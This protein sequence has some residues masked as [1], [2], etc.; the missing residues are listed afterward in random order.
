MQI[1][2][3]TLH[4]TTST[5]PVGAHNKLHADILAFIAS[6]PKPADAPDQ[7]V[8]CKLFDAFG[9]ATWW[10]TEYDAG[11]RIGF[12]YVTGLQ[13]DEWGSV[14]I[15]EL[16]ELHAGLSGMPG[17]A[18]RVEVDL[19]FRPTTKDEAV[20]KYHQNQDQT[21][22]LPE[23]EFESEPLAVPSVLSLSE[24]V[25]AF[26]S[27]LLDAVRRQ[28]P[29]VY[30]G[31][32]D[33]RREAV[34]D[35]LTR[36]PFPAQ[37]EV[38]QAV[39]AL[40]FDE[41]EPAGIIN[42][43][44]GTGKTMMAIA[45]AAV[46]HAEG[47]RRSLVIC[48]P[49]L[50]YK[51]RREIK[52]TVPHA[53]VWVLNGPDTLRKL[54][55]LREMRE[56]PL[57]P[58]FFVMGRVRMRMGYHWKPAFNLKRILVSEEDGE[59]TVPQG[60]KVAVC[61]HCH[62]WITDG[63]DSPLTPTQA[64]YHL[65]KE[66]R[67]CPQCRG[68]LWT[69]TRPQAS[70]KSRDE[71]VLSAMQQ[72]PTIGA[73]TAQ[74]LLATFGATML[75]DMLED[76]VYEFINLMDEDG[77][78]FFSDRQATRME[79]AMANSEFS[80]GQGGYQPTE[81]IK[82][83]L[84][85]GYFGLLIVDEGH[86][87]KNEGSAQGQAFG[88]LARKCSKTLLL[89]GTLMGG[90]ADDLFYLLWRLQPKA[91]MEDGFGY[92]RRGS[93][94]PASM[95]FLRAHGVIKDIYKTRDD[96]AKSHRTARGRQTVHRATKGPGFG[97]NGI[98]RYVVPIT[99]FL[100][101]KQIGG[102]VLPPYEEH[103]EGVA[104]TPVQLEWYRKLEEA[105]KEALKQAL[106]AGDHSLLGVVLNAL[107]AWP[108]CA[109]RAE[110]VVHPHHRNRVLAHVPA[111]FEG[112]ESMP[113]ER[114]LIERVKAEKTRGRRV[115]VYTVYTGTRDTTARLKALL[116]AE[117][118]KV[119]T[120]SASVAA[121]KRED[122][123]A[124][125][126]DRGIDVLVTNPELVKTGLDLLEFPTIVFLQSGYNVYTL[127]QAARRSW[128]I[129]QK[130]PVDVVFLGYQGTAQMACLELMAKKI[131]VAQSTSGDMPE[132]GLDVLN[133]SGDSIEVALARQ[134]VG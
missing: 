72:L 65:A 81:F 132:S 116:A 131:A 60:A 17:T 28:N 40:L 4:V 98:M 64:E 12:G 89:T 1:E 101:L 54:L 48:P 25:K 3:H 24:F 42:A 108:D 114:M 47:Y 68:A 125:Q 75:G 121:E 76:N 39:S 16:A 31:L 128:R 9:S 107:L 78:L 100:K 30:S 23:V 87:F 130:Q 79:R 66:R 33:A 8:I 46:A 11:D 82:R 36:A 84:P 41:D 10:L 71:M 115:L 104:M 13:F 73:K 34:M 38:V 32:P 37:R 5:Q 55:Q 122:W 105:L 15:D 91:M 61:P 14:S 27:G 62:T 112:S 18:P 19:H 53:R 99:A 83:Y 106:R 52:Q 59:S 92:S 117:G 7:W 43:E 97:P 120:L 74:R 90:Y 80:F 58:E 102:N 29:P 127:Q 93:L 96:E 111:L 63:D 126:V 21:P 69:L 35:S 134:L 133:Q 103:F 88:V 95:G 51:W 113:K 22:D 26:G 77:D 57:H 6:N 70:A 109:F 56:A 110:H 123:V 85:Q 2:H 67:F 49:H 94:G 50:V 45:A 119:A 129:G 44:M 124:D 86:E 118:L 20:T